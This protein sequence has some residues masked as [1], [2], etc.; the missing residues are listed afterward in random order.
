M[1]KS[2]KDKEEESFRVLPSEGRVCDDIE[3]SRSPHQT[4]GDKKRTDEM[5]CHDE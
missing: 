2:G 5:T 3:L 1:R 4:S